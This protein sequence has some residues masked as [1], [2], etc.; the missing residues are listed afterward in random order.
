MLF[1]ILDKFDKYFTFQLRKYFSRE[2][3]EFTKKILKF[4]FFAFSDKNVSVLLCSKGQE[5]VQ[6]IKRTVLFRQN[7]VLSNQ[8]GPFD[9]RITYDKKNIMN[10]VIMGIKNTSQQDNQ[11]KQILKK[12]CKKSIFPFYFLL[13][14]SFEKCLLN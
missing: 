1:K 2:F 4:Y 10:Y 9:I 6:N 5:Y 12:K 14:N 8:D 11:Q 7:S 13:A 3:A